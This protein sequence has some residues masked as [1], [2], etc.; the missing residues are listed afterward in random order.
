MVVLNICLLYLNLRISYYK[1]DAPKAIN[2]LSEFEHI[3][4]ASS[5]AYCCELPSFNKNQRWEKLRI[6]CLE[7]KLG[8]I[9]TKQG[10]QGSWYS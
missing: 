6:I 4:A 1:D 9:S 5:I 3:F 7:R 8:R 10:S 2:N